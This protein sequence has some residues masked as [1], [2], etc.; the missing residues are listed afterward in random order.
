MVTPRQDGVSWISR[1]SLSQGRTSIAKSINFSQPT[2]ISNA[3]TGTGF[4]PRRVCRRGRVSRGGSRWSAVGGSARALAAALTGAGYAVDGPLGR[5]ADGAGRRRRA[6]VRSRSGDRRGRRGDPPRPAGRALLGRDRARAARA[7]RGVLAAPA[8]DRHRHGASFAGAGAA[9][10]GST[11]ARAGAGHPA[12]ARARHGARSRSPSEDR[13]AYHAA[14][15][16]ASNFL[17]TLEAAAERLAAE[18]GVERR[19]LVPLVRATV[20]NWAA[21]GGRAGAHRAD[22][23]RRRGHGRAPARGDRGARARAARPVRRARRGDPRAW[24]P[25]TEPQPA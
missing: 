17:V 7:A 16:V 12:R 19:L 2:G 8:D 9:V 22:R 5:G 24:R 18:A 3:G 4:L 6:A 14:A 20:E 13:A 10:A 11:P 21:L 15:S 25:R 1:P 23:P